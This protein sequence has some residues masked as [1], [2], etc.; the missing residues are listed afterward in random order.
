MPPT[1]GVGGIFLFVASRRRGGAGL[2]SSPAPLVLTAMTLTY[3]IGDVHGR[4]DL[5]ERALTA[6]DR[7]RG[8]VRSRIIMLGDYVDRGPDSAGVV[9][10]LRA[11]ERE[12][13]IVCLKGNHEEI[14]VEALASGDTGRW[15]RNGGRA[16]LDS[17]SGDV[18]PPDLAWM[19]AL[20]FVHEDA[21]R[22]YVHGGLKP[23]V[24]VADQDEHTCLWIR[25]RFLKA[26][27]E[28]LPAH[29]V[30]GHTPRWKGKRDL[31]A[32][33]LLPHRTN[34]DTAAFRT[35]RLT[36]GIFETDQPGGAVELLTII[37]PGSDLEV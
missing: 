4:L 27:G 33:E 7:H 35:G 11:L 28:A 10:T 15:F 2:R 37:G 22:I 12:R 23:G 6:I 13:H 30:H 8:R 16:T 25:D 29:V 17:Y 26:P 34:L 14:M 9:G 32:C 36:V 20:P 5:L 31:T 1:L 18:D 3:A 21:H 24:A 19:A